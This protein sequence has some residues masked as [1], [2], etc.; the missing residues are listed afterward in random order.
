MT[1]INVK[2]TI[3]SDRMQRIYDWIGIEA[4]SPSKIHASLP[5]NNAPIEVVINSG[6]GDVFAGSEIFT[7]LKEYAGEVTVKIVGLA[8]SAA[9]VIAM[10]GDKVLISPTA[11]IMI[12]NVSTS[13]GGDYR[14]FEH[15]AEVLKSANQSIA[16][17][18]KT[19]TKKTD[20]ELKNLMD[21]ETWFNA[22]S[23]I[24]HGFADEVM[25]EEKNEQA[26]VAD[27]FG[28]IQLNDEA[29]T[30]ITKLIEADIKPSTSTHSG[31]AELLARL[32]ILELGG[33]Y[34]G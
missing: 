12:H 10:A 25:F 18:Y 34:N 2:G 26:L 27:L 33:N 11:Q 15:T 28:G 1:K 16:N 21:S 13:V 8:A 3:I 7:T 24:E 22:K 17:A 9:S 29:I 32:K 5:S 6:G 30:K 14:T 23:A 4:T 19:K 20:E 31:E